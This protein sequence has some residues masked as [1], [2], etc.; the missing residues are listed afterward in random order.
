M[1]RILTL[2]LIVV[3]TPALADERSW[4]ISGFERIRVEGPFAVRVTTGPGAS[5]KARASGDARALDR[6]TVRVDGRTLIITRN[7]NGQG[8]TR[9]SEGA[10]AIEVSVPVLRA[11]Y[12]NG[13]ATLDVNAM[14]GARIDLAVSGP[15]A[16]RVT[17]IDGDR[18]AATLI[19]NGS[20]TLAGKALQ[21][22]FQS[23]GAGTIDASR[24]VAGALTVSAQGPGEGRYAARNTADISASG[25][26]AISVVGNPACTVLGT[27][28]VVCG[29]DKRE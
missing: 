27:A 25:Q 23:N 21:A 12:V 15:G 3:A 6:V 17:R 29:P 13:A 26:G 10:P 8:A 19:G 4:M 9:A 20:L 2:A 1:L 18:L 24:L 11:A 16:I 14:T 28:P 22:R 5:P 7:I